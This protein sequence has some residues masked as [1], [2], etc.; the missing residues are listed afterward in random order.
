MGSNLDRLFLDEWTM[1]LRP[2]GVTLGTAADR[3]G[4]VA[5]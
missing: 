3:P 4:V 5:P 1:A 2:A